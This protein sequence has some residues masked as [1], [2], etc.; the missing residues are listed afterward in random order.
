MVL[1]DDQI[2]Y[3]ADFTTELLRKLM[4]TTCVRREGNV[5]VCVCSQG[6]RVAPGLWSFPVGGGYPSQVGRQGV[7]QSGL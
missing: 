5:L 7:P 4:F 6:M 1:S 2:A 3:S